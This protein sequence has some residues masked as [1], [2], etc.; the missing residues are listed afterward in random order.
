M[1]S[2]GGVA[3]VM[4]IGTVGDDD[5]YD[6][7]RV[8]RRRCTPVSLVCPWRSRRI[9]ACWFYSARSLSGPPCGRPPNDRSG[10]DVFAW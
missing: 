3:P 2:S 6:L 5:N 1:V 8:G 4:V 10:I 9:A 7:S